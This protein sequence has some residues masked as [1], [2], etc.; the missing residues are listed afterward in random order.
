MVRYG[1]KELKVLY[2]QIYVLHFPIYSHMAV[3]RCFLTRKAFLGKFGSR[4]GKGR[5]GEVHL[6]VHLAPLLREPVFY[7]AALYLN[8]YFTL[9]HFTS[10]C[11]L[12]CFTFNTS[13]CILP[14][15]TLLEF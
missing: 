14:R 11:I 12:P 1:V 4:R 7:P 8:L 2:I 13:T 6:L 15:C 10:A 3:S 9:L 5:G